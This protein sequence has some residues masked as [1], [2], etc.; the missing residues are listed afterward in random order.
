MRMRTTL[1]AATIAALLAATPAGAEVLGKE[2]GFFYVKQEEKLK[3]GPGPQIDG[4]VVECPNG[5]G[6]TGGG[7]TVTGELA[8]T[9]MSSNS[10]QS[11]TEWY[12]YGWHTGINPKSETVTAWAVCTPKVGK[13]SFGSEVS[14]ETESP[15]G[16]HV[17]AE[18]SA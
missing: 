10:V 15:G 11:P 4:A 18:C 6:V 7:A 5:T 1:L 12:M 17:V 13:V 9:A 3:K 2:G 8:G 14:P 16:N